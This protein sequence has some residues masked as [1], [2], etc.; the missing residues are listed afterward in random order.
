MYV[1]GGI[2]TAYVGF[3]ILQIKSGN[4]ELFTKIFESN[5]IFFALFKQKILRI[6]ENVRGTDDFDCITTNEKL[7]RQT[8][9]SENTTFLK[10]LNAPYTT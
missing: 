7:F 6:G 2:I 3:M 5:T 10:Y 9:C 1:H 4:F 8:I